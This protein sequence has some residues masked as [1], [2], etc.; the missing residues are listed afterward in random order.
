MALGPR[1]DL[2]S[3]APGTVRNCPHWTIETLNSE[4]TGVARSCGF[5][6]P[7]TNRTHP[8]DVTFCAKK[9]RIR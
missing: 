2:Q 5:P 8:E 7:F 9:D 3:L 6:L 4:I 1:R